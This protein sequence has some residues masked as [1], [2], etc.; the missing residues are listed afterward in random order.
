MMRL[1][2]ACALSTLV[3]VSAIAD[4]QSPPSQPS[5][6]ASTTLVEVDAV[7]TNHRGQFVNGLNADDFEVLE[8]GKPQQIER[9]YV[10]TGRV[11]TAATT[12]TVAADPQGA[13]PRSS[14][15][16]VFILFFDQDHLQEGPFKRLQDAAVA[17][18]S[19]QFSEGDVGGVVIGGTMLG[20]RLTTD[21]EAL[22]AAVRDA[23]PNF[24]KTSR[25]LE[26][27][28]WPRLN[29]ETEA[30]RIA[31]ANDREV[32]AQAVRRAC[33]D[34]RSMCRAIDPEPA[35]MEK[36]R[37]VVGD[38][39]PAA[40]RTVMAL[41]ALAMGLARLPGR[42]A[43]VLMTEGFF[44][45][46][47]WADLRQIVGASAR[48]NVRIYSIDARGLDTR[49]VNDPRQLAPMDPGG[50]IPL[51]AY[52]TIDDGPNMLAVN[53]G[54]YAIRHTNAFADA[55]SEI[56]R[57]TGTYYVIGY[58]PANSTLDGSFRKIAVRLKRPG[59][60]VRARRGYLATPPPP[61]SASPPAESKSDPASESITSPPVAAT[62]PV[63]ATAAGEARAATVAP[64]TELNPNA[65]TVPAA[66]AVAAKVRLRP[67]T[68][69]RVRTLASDASDLAS[70]ESA[71]SQGW[72]RYQKGDLEG[73]AELLRKGAAEGDARPWVR[74]AL[75]YAELGLRQFGNAAEAW[76]R[77]RAAVPEFRA[78]YL[79][80]ADAY[81]QAENYGR[82]IDV[83]KIAD[84]RWPGDV[85][86]LNAM[87]TIQV[88]RGALNDAIK[89]F[90]RATEARPDDGLAYF[91]LGRTYALRYFKL[92][93]YSQ[94]EGR[95]ISDPT[96]VKNAIAS[97]ERYIAIGGPYE[98]QAR[99]AI[100]NLQWVK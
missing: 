34:D 40:R 81:F 51:E 32:L 89:T 66:A 100:Q 98:G 9:A 56:A 3:A 49:Q 39:R 23:K 17:F 30:I 77:V 70:D 91:N 19:A 1:L 44:V 68:L 82:A 61:S 33:E 54:G 47:S 41:E 79:D 8:D 46:E 10:V 37:R 6:R 45:E 59:L 78:V 83:L 22:L 57:D 87:G 62:T 31:L 84:T 36:A 99:E 73:A 75:G 60:T 80:L 63:P 53:T 64:A 21:R 35:I 5:F 4:A 15:Q 38:L 96:D 16:R 20:N 58:R 27:L 92:R 52:N 67:D 13:T 7:V 48:S 25:R 85:D 28:E 76:E 71:A 50:S 94:V 12:S 88:R 95:W 18:L 74:Y 65:A 29:S 14:S 11:T 86:V 26:L 93:R 69:D 90:K 24:A 2:V 43:I 55:L 97:Y 72:D 42:K